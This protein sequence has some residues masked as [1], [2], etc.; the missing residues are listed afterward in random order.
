MAV[1]IDRH[2]STERYHFK[3]NMKSGP[4]KLSELNNLYW[5]GC[6]YGPPG[7]GKSIFAGGSSKLRTAIIDVD[8][9]MQSVKAYRKR[10]GMSEDN[11][12]IFAIKSVADFDAAVSW[13]SVNIKDFDLVVVDSMTEL[14]RLI[15]GEISEQAKMIVPGQREWGI[16]RT[17]MENP[18]V[19]F[20]YM[21]VHFLMTAHEIN[22]FDPDFGR[23]VWRPSFD[24]RYAFEYA[25]HL[26]YICRYV[27]YHKDG[28]K[29]A[30]GKP[31]SVL[32]RALNFGPDPYAHT[33]DRSGMMRRWEE[34]SLDDILAKMAE[35]SNSSTED[36]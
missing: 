3:M 29:G 13:I 5:K 34:P 36:E 27:I 14:Q 4:I 22:K 15:V 6:V 21:P 11:I 18:T 12:S 7:V 20:R 9:G 8:N 16:I 23:D 2:S 19:R 26:S 17:L 33:K 1:V 35:S 24:G 30:D 25:K 10:H 28:P 32:V 31:T